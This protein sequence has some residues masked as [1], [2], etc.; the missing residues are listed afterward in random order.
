MRYV[1]ALA[2]E[3]ESVND[4]D[5]LS[6][7]ADETGVKLEPSPEALSTWKKNCQSY[8]FQRSIRL[9]PGQRTFAK[10]C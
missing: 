2:L 7:I 6:A 1:A 4:N 9:R 5:P 3:T 10:M 8:W